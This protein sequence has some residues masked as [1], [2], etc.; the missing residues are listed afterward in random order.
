[1][2]YNNP[3][4]KLVWLN[5]KSH[6]LLTEHGDNLSGGQKKRLA[7]ARGLLRKKKIILMDENTANV[8][9]KT[10]CQIEPFIFNLKECTDLMITHHLDGQLAKQYAQ[11]IE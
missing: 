2:L 6:F 11:T 5:S 8:A 7:L 10:L 1:M 9:P 4:N 3:Y